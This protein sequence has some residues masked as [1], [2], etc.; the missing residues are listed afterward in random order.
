[1]P[2]ATFV[3]VRAG[4][5][6]CRLYAHEVETTAS[7]AGGGVEGWQRGAPVAARPAP[8]NISAALSVVTAAPPC[9]VRGDKRIAPQYRVSSVPVACHE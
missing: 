4:P 5:A 9:A 1:M 3:A 8:G 2:E 6:G 7:R